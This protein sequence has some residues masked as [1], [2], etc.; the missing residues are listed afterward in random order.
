[1]SNFQKTWRPQEVDPLLAASLSGELFLP[2]PAARALAAR[3]RAGE[4]ARRFLDGAPADL[5]DPLLMAGI[6]QATDRIIA[7]ILKR[8]KTV[9][10]GD[11]DVDG[12]T[13]SALLFSFFR[14]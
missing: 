9:I 2:P 8:E 10:F 7:A 6:G 1:M 13:S 3:V 4:A 12:I 5:P 14:E 11:Y